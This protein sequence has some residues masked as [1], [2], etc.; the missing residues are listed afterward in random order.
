MLREV[1]RSFP[2]AS[3]GERSLARRIETAAVA[4]ELASVVV[5]DPEVRSSAYEPDRC[6]E[7]GGRATE[8]AHLIPRSRGG[9]ATVP[10]CGPCHGRMHDMERTQD[11]STLTIEG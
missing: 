7:C 1:P 4:L 11:I 2:C 9:R 10:L 5:D 3:Q 6:W 8:R